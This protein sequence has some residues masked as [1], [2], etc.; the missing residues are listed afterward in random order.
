MPTAYPQVRALPALRVATLALFFAFLL[1]TV[2]FI[3]KLW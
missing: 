3:R 1:L 2:D